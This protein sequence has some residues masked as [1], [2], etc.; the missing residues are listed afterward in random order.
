MTKELAEARMN[1]SAAL[2]LA[3]FTPHTAS[4]SV[5]PFAMVKTK[6]THIGSTA[7]DVADALDLLRAGVLRSVKD[8][9]SQ[10]A[11]VEADAGASL[12]A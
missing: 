7:H 6:L 1:R 4:T 3:V 9:E 11:V 8:L 10:L 5:T 2:A 12:T